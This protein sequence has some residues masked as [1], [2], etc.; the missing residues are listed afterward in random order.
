MI[1]ISLKFLNNKFYE[2]I[3]K[4]IIYILYILINISCDRYFGVL[5]L[6]L[7]VFYEKA[8]SLNKKQECKK[9]EECYIHKV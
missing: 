4:T 8:D 2:T 6:L 9:V 5:N 7:K 3:N 1:F